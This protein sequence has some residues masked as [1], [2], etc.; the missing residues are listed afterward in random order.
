MLKTFFYISIVVAI[1]DLMVF[2]YYQSWSFQISHTKLLAGFLET[3][4][5][6]GIMFILLVFWIAYFVITKDFSHIWI[7]SV[8]LI[9]LAGYFLFGILSSVATDYKNNND[10]ASWLKKS[11][12]LVYSSKKLG[13]SFQYISESQ[14]DGAITVQENGD[15]I[16][17]N[18]EKQPKGAGA[19]KIFKK[20]GE[21]SLLDYLK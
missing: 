3:I 11:N 12:D 16:Y 7:P 19:L 2:F 13:I 8:L 4:V 10:K 15:N 14:Y 21:T 17:L 1:A 5:T 9:I 6:L 18:L 20:D